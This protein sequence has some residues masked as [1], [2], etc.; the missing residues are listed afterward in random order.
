MSEGGA[1]PHAEALYYHIAKDS[2]EVA[3]NEEDL[4]KRKQAVTTSFVFSALCL[5]AFINQQY[6]KHVSS[7]DLIDEFERKRLEEKWLK[8]PSEL[9]ATSEFE[10]GEYP[11]QVF[12]ELV[13]T[14]NHRLV[15]FKP[16]KETQ[17]TG[18]I[19][20]DEY[21]GELVGNIGLAET[22]LQCVKDMIIK[23]NVLTKGATEI[24]AFLE[25]DKY[26]S[27]VWSSVTIN[28]DSI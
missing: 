17:I 14:R 23:L 27:H 25:G 16:H 13:K 7:N 19:Y 22:Y 11:F 21:F 24:P 28:I 15:H 5:E 2:L 20:K 18:N 8:L 1:R 10:K 12:K 4:F 3:K 6:A 9:G 26:V